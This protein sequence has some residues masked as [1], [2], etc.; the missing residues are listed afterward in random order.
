MERGGIHAGVVLVDPNKL[1]SFSYHSLRQSTAKVEHRL[2]K[3][4]SSLGVSF[5]PTLQFQ[6]VLNA[7]PEQVHSVL[8]YLALLTIPSIKSSFVLLNGEKNLLK[9]I[10]SKWRS[11][12][13][14]IKINKLKQREQV[15]RYCNLGNRHFWKLD[16]KEIV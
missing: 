13:R 7:S 10:S 11:R 16:L 5:T 15:L 3:L 9:T 1:R 8:K 2:T 14:G 4:C 12:S 6:L